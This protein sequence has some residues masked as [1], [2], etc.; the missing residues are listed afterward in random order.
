MNIVTSILIIPV[1]KKLGTTNEWIPWYSPSM[2]PMS[3]IV[4]IPTCPIGLEFK[5]EHSFA[6]VNFMYCSWT[7]TIIQ[8]KFIQLIVNYAWSTEKTLNSINIEANAS[9]FFKT[10]EETFI[11]LLVADCEIWTNDLITK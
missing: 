5:R 4:V 7:Y 10:L 11:S 3:A 9:E 6:E 2:V 1:Y 8:Y